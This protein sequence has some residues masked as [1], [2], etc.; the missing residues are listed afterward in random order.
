[1][2]CP[3]RIFIILLVNNIHI[4]R[5]SSALVNITRRT[6][7]DLILN[8][9]SQNLIEVFKAVEVY[10][11]LTTEEKQNTSKTANEYYTASDNPDKHLNIVELV[12]KYGY[13]ITVHRVQTQDGYI[14]K[15]FRIPGNGPAVF[16]M[17]GLLCSADDWVTAGS[18]SG[19]AYVLASAGYDVWLGNARGNKYSR[20]HRS[21]SPDNDAEH[22]WDFSWDEI[23]RYDLAAMIDYILRHTGQPTLKYVGHS[24]GTTSFFVLCSERPE[25]NEKISLMAALSPVA[26]MSHV[27]SAM[28]RLFS[29]ANPLLYRI[30]KLFGVY[31]FIPSNEVTKAVAD[32]LCGTTTLATILCSNILFIIGGFDF[33]QLNIT[34]LPVLFGHVPAGS[35]TKQLVHYGQGVQSGEFKKFDYGERINI[36]I[37]GSKKPPTYAVEKITAPV[38]LFYSDSD[39]LSN[40]IDVNILKSKLPNV[41]DFYKVPHK[42]FNHFDYLWAKDVKDL[43][44]NRLL[45]LLNQT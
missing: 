1:M 19:I 28:L 33:D 15:M 43:V 32:V 23:G 4:Q 39:W 17:H 41:I 8:P 16:L 12:R 45:Q 11:P 37:Y 5:A 13:P 35:A 10:R 26:W 25:Y 18:E 30:A 42:K 21:L 31:E 38:A 6:K 7:K 36:E 14:L 29:S 27:E 20:H 24:Q 2:V 22:F 3:T 9:V 34:N 44:I 40:V